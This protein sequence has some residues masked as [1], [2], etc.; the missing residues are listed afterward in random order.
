MLTGRTRYR[1]GWFG[2]LVVQVEYWTTLSVAGQILVRRH[3]RHWRDARAEDMQ[4][5]ERGDVT[6]EEPAPVRSCPR[7]PS[8]A[9]PAP[10]P[11]RKACQYPPEPSPT[12]PA[13]TK[14]LTWPPDEPTAEPPPTP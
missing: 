3:V 5:I 11:V 8:S 13:R 12:T 9:P 2:R 6:A 4:D 1:I 14:P 7:M 10:R